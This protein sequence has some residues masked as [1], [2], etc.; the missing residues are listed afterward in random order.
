MLLLLI[1]VINTSFFA[2]VKFHVVIVSAC[3]EARALLHLNFSFSFSNPFAKLL[4]Q[5]PIK[6]PSRTVRPLKTPFHSVSVQAHASTCQYMPV[7][8]STCQNVPERA[9]HT[10]NTRQ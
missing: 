3:G 2:I 5:S 9:S 6:L 4:N 7:H 8:A 10:P 1:V